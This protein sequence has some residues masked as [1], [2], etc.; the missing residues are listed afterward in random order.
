MDKEA[1]KK[2]ALETVVAVARVNEEFTPDDIWD[3]GLQKP[4]EGRWLGPVMNAA[5]NKGY[6]EKT[7]RVQPTRQKESHGC[8]VTIWRSKIYEA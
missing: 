4:I 1:W 5:K 3:A 2:K 8:D 7:G 6:I